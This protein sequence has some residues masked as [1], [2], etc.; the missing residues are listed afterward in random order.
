[1]GEPSKSSFT[2]YMNDFYKSLDEMSKNSSDISFREPVREKC[3]SIYE[4]YQ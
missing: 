1:M 2:Q 3:L 4:T